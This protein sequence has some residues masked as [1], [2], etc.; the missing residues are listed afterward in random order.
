MQKDNMRFIAWFKSWFPLAIITCGLVGLIYAAAQQ[1]YRLSANDPQ[2]QLAYDTPAGVLN[3]NA[4]DVHNSLAPFVITYDEKQSVIDAGGTLHGSPL[5]LPPRI[6]DYV[7]SHGEDR[8]TWEPENGVRL[9]TVVVHHKSGYVLAARNLREV[10]NRIDSMTLRVATGL[11]VIL[12][13]SGVASWVTMSLE[14]PNR[15]ERIKK[16]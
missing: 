12:I 5:V 14:L 13:L 10:E 9:A 8:F 15:L 4:I 6:L 2:V 16:S 3:V 11:M 7:K 1:N